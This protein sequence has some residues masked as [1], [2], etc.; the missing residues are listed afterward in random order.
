MTVH[1][2][3]SKVFANKFDTTRGLSRLPEKKL[4]NKG[5]PNRFSFSELLYMD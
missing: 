2:V 4:A 3:V 5:V 1:Y